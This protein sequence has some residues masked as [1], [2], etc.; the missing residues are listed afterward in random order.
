MSN[1]AK[2][3]TSA[4]EQQSA[5]SAAPQ[6]AQ[7]SGLTRGVAHWIHQHPTITSDNLIGYTGYQF[8][9]SAVAS[10]PYGFS[11][12]ATWLGMKNL[13]ELGKGMAEAGEA[14]GSLWKAAFGKNLHGLVTYKPVLMSAMIGTSFT[15][16]RSTSK[17]GKWTN[18]YL[19]NNK[20]TEEQTVEKL[21]NLPGV[22]WG[23]IKEV[24]PGE[25]HSTPVAAVVL[26][27]LV[28]S[29]DPVG[30]PAALRATQSNFK[31]AQAE[32][33]AGQFFKDM[34]FHPDAKL[35]QQCATNTF[36]YSLFFEVGDRRFKD[37][38]IEQGKWDGNPS[39]I[40]GNRS[41]PNPGLSSS[42]NQISDD[43]KLRVLQKG[44]HADD[45]LS[46]FT[47]EPSLGRFCFRRMVP[48][49]IGITGYTM[50]KMRAAPMMLGHFTDGLKTVSD[51]P[52]HAWREGA[53]TSLFFM[54]PWVS[55]KYAPMYDR[56]VDR[57]EE[58]V[59][60]KPVQYQPDLPPEDRQRIEKNQ[61]DLLDKVREKAKGVGD[62]VAGR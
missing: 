57:L 21:Q 56:V 18:E 12:A 29:F 37:K 23:K 60:G 36:A 9:R 49:A 25:L 55:D 27:F 19:F 16:Y 35:L 28:S 10:V 54:I 26:G 1:N 13:G 11:M 62:L 33:R 38:Q 48:T 20:D 14:S 61:Q 43:E 52:T 39:S 50:L 17:I 40:S 59:S 6:A 31:L 24:A 53:A 46:F 34:L 42:N 30:V 41:R 7:A 22:V 8:V 51:I 44:A 2:I 5:V 3:M 45:K 15:L 4:Q 47:G 58:M 32:G